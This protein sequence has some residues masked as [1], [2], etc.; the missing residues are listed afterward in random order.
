MRELPV[1]YG[2]NALGTDYEISIPEIAVDQ[3][4]VGR[5]GQALFEPLERRLE[6]RVRVVVA[7]IGRHVLLELLA[8]RYRVQLG[9]AL[10][11]DLVYARQ[12][13][14]ALERQHGPRMCIFR[15]SQDLAGDCLAFDAR[16]HIAG[17]DAVA[18]RQ[19]VGHFRNADAGLVRQLQNRG[20]GVVVGCGRRSLGHNA[21]WCTAQDERDGRFRGFEVKGPGFLTGASGE[22]LQ[23]CDT[24]RAGVDGA[25]GLLEGGLDLVDAGGHPARLPRGP[26]PRQRFRLR[27]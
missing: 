1:Q 13:F 23:P 25:Q 21:P 20:L 22:L 11:G 7:I 10:A 19:D 15:V 24:A 16:H 3:C 14:P 12:G 6:G 5:V 8:R 26:W 18:F 2:A 9:Q 17:T 4:Q 27:R